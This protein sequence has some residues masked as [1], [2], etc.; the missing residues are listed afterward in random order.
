MGLHSLLKKK[1]KNRTKNIF[2]FEQK[3]SRK[4]KKNSQLIDWAS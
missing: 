2:R 3:P 4:N 1:K